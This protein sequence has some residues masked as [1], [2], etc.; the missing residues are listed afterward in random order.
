[1]E[2]F[3][4]G[5]LAFPL[6]HQ[7]RFSCFAVLLQTKE[8]KAANVP[9]AFENLLSEVIRW[10]KTRA[11]LQKCSFHVNIKAFRRVFWIYKLQ[12][13]NGIRSCISDSASTQWCHWHPY[14]SRSTFV[15]SVIQTTLLHGRLMASAAVMWRDEGSYLLASSAICEFASRGE[16]IDEPQLRWR[17]SFGRPQFVRVRR[18]MSLGP[19]NSHSVNERT[20]GKGENEVYLWTT[21]SHEKFLRLFSRR[22]TQADA[23]HLLHSP[24][25]LS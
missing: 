1:M 2:I 11:H 13:G 15:R 3:S 4:P 22:W 14:S 17:H 24:V 9:F 8:F 19:W 12:M 23:L 20:G 21:R 10:P 7:M 6:K 16:S 18:Q 25:G 5:K